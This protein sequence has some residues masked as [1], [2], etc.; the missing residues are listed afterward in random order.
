MELSDLCGSTVCTILNCTIGRLGRKEDV[1]FRV[2]SRLW[3]SGLVNLLQYNYRVSS[4]LL[5]EF[6][7]GGR[8]DREVR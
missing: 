5:L 8:R 2:E 7:E 3:Y 1:V 4:K 6:R